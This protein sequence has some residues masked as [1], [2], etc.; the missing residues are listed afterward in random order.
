MARVGNQVFTQGLA[1]AWTWILRRDA[2]PGVSPEFLGITRWSRAR[3]HPGS[4]E[5]LL[6][7]WS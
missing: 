4:T 3:T 2:R 1:P 7:L 5:W 6:S